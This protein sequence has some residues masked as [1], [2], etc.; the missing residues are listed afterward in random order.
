M[1]V[2]VNLI[3]VRQKFS[4]NHKGIDF[5]FD[6]KILGKNQ[7][8]YAA[9]DGMIIYNRYQ[10]SGG[11]V[12]H[13]R[14]DSGYITEYGH[15][16]KDSQLVKEGDKVKKGQKI[17]LMGNSGNVTGYHLHFGVYKGTTINYN[18][19]S[20]FVDPKP[21]LCMYGDQQYRSNSLIKNFAKTKTA[22]GIPSEPLL[23]HNKAD[24]KDSSVVKD[25]KI[26]NGNEVEYY[27]YKGKYA[28]VDNT[29]NYY[30]SKKHLK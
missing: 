6:S 3:N 25:F 4:Q 1:K 20:N 11:Y 8:I 5:G 22:T 18:K 16:K 30:T 26:F 24:F 12:I 7:P 29:R 17:A 15:L 13:I 2:P 27:G 28:I 14:H 19:T 23:V 10:K 9:D 21:F